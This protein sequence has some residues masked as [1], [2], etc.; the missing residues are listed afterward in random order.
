M[1]KANI[2]IISV[3]LAM[4]ILLNIFS[5]TRPVYA[6]MTLLDKLTQNEKLISVTDK[7][8]TYSDITGHWAREGIL[9][10]SYME[11]LKGF[12]DGSM[13]PDK[14]LTRE[15]FIV[16]LA[17]AID[18]PLTD[19]YVQSYQDVEVGRWSSQYIAAAKSMG[20]L[21]IFKQGVMY[22]AKNITREE[23]AVIAAKAVQDMPLTSQSKSFKD[24]NAAYKYLDSINI[25]TSLDIIRGMPDGSF[26]PYNGATRAEAAVVIQRILDLKSPEDLQENSE[27]T[28]FA[29]NYEKSRMTNPIQGTFS[30]EDIML[31][32]IG[33]EQ[34]QNI[35]RDTIISSLKLQSINL[36]RSISNSYT[37]ISYKSRYLAEV[38]VSYNMT[39]A[40]VEGASREYKITRKLYMKRDKGK[41]T[42]YDSSVLYSILNEVNVKESEKINLTWHNLYNSSPNMSGTA[43]IEGLDVI[44]PTWFTLSSANGD[45]ANIASLDYT[46]WA[47][48]NGYKVWAL[49]GN[50]FDRDLTSKVLNNEAARKNA[51]DNLIKFIKDYNLDGI[52]IDFEYMY[53]S[54]KDLFTK[55]VGELYQKTKPLGVKLSVDVTVIAYNSDWS[56]CYDRKAL[57]Q[58]SDYIALMAYDQYWTGSPVSGSVSQ[59]RWVEDNL[60]KVLLEVPNNK[61]L[62]GIPFYTRVWKEAYVANGKLVVTSSS[63]SMQTAERL[64]AENNA[65]RTWDAVSGQFFVTYKKDGA[66]YKIWMEDEASI[67]LRVEMANMYDLAGV[68]SWRMGFEKPQIWEV[69]NDNLK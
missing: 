38:V 63:V 24:L 45:Y 9:K 67:K 31:F 8:Y 65:A 3:V 11:I 15:E 10:L 28:S 22:P 23:M 59:L 2:K 14:T 50:N 51:V 57:A 60:K 66:V 41:W 46:S 35:K 47:H 56:S 29:E 62:L 21:D 64:A 53:T 36:N 61:L 26:E 33:K 4:S 1:R 7:S 17:R 32:S 48:K 58:V 68:A 6:D 43:K 27:I 12:P 18:L 30:T 52:N 42:V 20:F 37:F 54:D 69:I 5:F 49:V 40:T 13:R 16:M 55:F 19:T 25:V 39:N 34:K 44:S